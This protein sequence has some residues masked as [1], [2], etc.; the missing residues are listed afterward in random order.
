MDIYVLSNSIPKDAVVFTHANKGYRI[1][2][3]Y[4]SRSYRRAMPV[5]GAR[6]ET[7]LHVYQLAAI[8]LWHKY[9]CI[10][11]IRLTRTHERSMR[12]TVGG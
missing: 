10:G 11:R 8:D 5:Y 6:E 1:L 4:K 9:G 7:T 12:R 2:D 3:N